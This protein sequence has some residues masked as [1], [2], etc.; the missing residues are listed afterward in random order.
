M[1]TIGLMN[2]KVDDI[3]NYL[4]DM[5]L[6]PE[7]IPCVPLD[8]AKRK[9]RSDRLC[10]DLIAGRE[11]V[12]DLVSLLDRESF[13][14]LLLSDVK[15][16]KTKKVREQSNI[17]SSNV[18]MFK[19]MGTRLRAILILPTTQLLTFMTLTP[20]STKSACS[21]PMLSMYT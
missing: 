1:P 5:G 7:P 15:V 13:K 11:L 18:F 4:M 14:K 10:R 20:T 19:A 3:Q 17:N 16:R 21:S 2:E 8:T 9:S 12:L 6:P